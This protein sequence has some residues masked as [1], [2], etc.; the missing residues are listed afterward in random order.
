MPLARLRQASGSIAFK[1]SLILLAMGGATAAAIAVALVVFT[2][3]S[4]SIEALEADV[5]PEIGVSLAVANAASDT[6]DAL[7]AIA[8]SADIEALEAAGPGYDA[9]LSGLVE[10]ISR[11]PGD[12]AG[13]MREGTAALEGAVGDL[14]AA[15]RAEFEARARMEGQIA[16]LEA[17]SR[18]ARE[19]LTSL[20]SS[21][22]FLLKFSGD[23]TVATV[24]DTLSGLTDREFAYL[25]SALGVRA[26]LNLATGLSLAISESR[27]PAFAAILADVSAGAISRAV[28]G[29][30]VLAANPSYAEAVGP[31]VAGTARLSEI[32]DNG[33]RG[34]R[35]LRDELLSIRQ[36]ADVVLSNFVDD[37]SFSLVILAE[38]TAEGNEAAIRDLLRG[39]VQKIIDAGRVDAAISQL[40]IAALI[41]VSGG[42]A[43]AV[44]SAQLALDA[45]RADLDDI[46][47]DTEI[48]AIAEI[49]QELSSLTVP[50][51]GVVASRQAYLEAISAS[52]EASETASDILA[53]IVDGARVQG[54]AALSRVS[55]AGSMVLSQTRQ[56]GER[57]WIIATT[58]IAIFAIA[59]VLT[60]WLI[61]RPLARVANETERLSSGDLDPVR[62]L[63]RQGGEIGRMASA[64]SV[65]REGIIARQELEAQEKEREA[66]ERRRKD[67]ADEEKRRAAEAAAAEKERQAEAERER[68]AAE[69]ARRRE[70]EATAQA[71][72]DAR[73]AEQAIVVDALAQA[74]NRLAEG[75]LTA[76]IDIAFPDG[77]A[78]VKTNFNAA[79]GALAE[80]MTDLTESATNVEISAADIASAAR[81]LSERTERAAASL[82]ET[83]AAVTEL[84]ASARSA[85]QGA[86]DAD[87]RM[88]DVRLEVDR[89]SRKMAEAVEMMSA[90]E[91]S[92]N[93]IAKITNLIEDIAFQT[94]LLALNAGVE[95]ARAG[96][97][98]QGFAVV[99]TEVRNL[100][101]RSS[102][103]ASEINDLISTTRSQITSG[104]ETVSSAGDGIT[105]IL[106][107]VEGV[108]ENISR[109]ATTSTGQAGTISEIGASVGDLDRTTQQNA[110]MFEES[111][112]AS[113]LLKG[114]AGSLLSLARRFNLSPVG[115][116]EAS[117][118]DESTR[119]ALAS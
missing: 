49:S 74:M 9:A 31:L 73:A 102:D 51:V 89:G 45:A 34:G 19:A 71:E 20:Q 69:A 3:L 81:A 109:I 113:E 107:A 84:D 98:G 5:L 11:L 91:A 52:T 2:D 63:D 29:A 58:G 80:A 90:I 93:K 23:E 92:S 26:D 115:P 48:D 1:Q 8:S 82:E 114:E 112:A 108:A 27:D 12:A 97:K 46:L 103:A 61:L 41:G 101:Q 36:D 7:D 6:G 17:L 119:T 86:G 75:D 47:A 33:F 96:E 39:Q 50:E 79:V 35:A 53:G 67:L 94:N 42:D 100:A 32:A 30:A 25:Q 4:R 87:K 10:G 68:E 76:S 60:F 95:A 13:P 105:A 21:T 22:F 99:A 72:R 78:E 77:Y 88:S 85:S 62:G 111:L 55:S 18:D 118:L 15:R 66:E 43:E 83:A 16:A 37:L 104:V 44:S 70:I 24:R 54:E 40:L 117:D 28:E 116:G 14:D 57:M 56:A 64:L 106:R 38:E 65:F 110:A 59:L